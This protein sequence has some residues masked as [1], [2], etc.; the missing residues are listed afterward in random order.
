MRTAVRGT[1]RQISGMFAIEKDH[2]AKLVLKG[3]V[4][5]PD[6]GCKATQVRHKMTMMMSIR[7]R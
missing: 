6:N 3:C 7:V 1:R 2:G 5:M 4:D